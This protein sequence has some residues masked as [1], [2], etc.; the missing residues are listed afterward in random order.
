MSEPARIWIVVLV[1]T[2]FAAPS[3]RGPCHDFAPKRT[4]MIPVIRQL[5]VLCP[6]RAVLQTSASARQVHGRPLEARPRDLRPFLP[7]K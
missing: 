5:Q 4:S 1:A 3:E 6:H 7:R 2:R